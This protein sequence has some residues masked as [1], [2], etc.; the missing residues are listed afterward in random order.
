MA[1]FCIS[2]I[3]VEGWLALWLAASWRSL[4]TWVV[5]WPLMS[6]VCVINQPYRGRTQPTPVSEF[7]A[8]SA[9]LQ[10][11]W[12]KVLVSKATIL[13]TSKQVFSQSTGCCLIFSLG[14]IISRVNAP[15]W[16]SSLSI[17]HRF[18]TLGEEIKWNKRKLW[19][20][21]TRCEAAP[22]HPVDQQK[23]L[24]SELTLLDLH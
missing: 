3:T 2:E 6:P 13:D 17:L 24:S 4:S 10:S 21:K 7:T 15:V 16:C 18:K 14:K 19:K 5:Q 12:S 23:L 20:A 22:R 9:N 8:Y 11:D 1:L